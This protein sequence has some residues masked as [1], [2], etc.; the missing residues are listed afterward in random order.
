MAF[1]QDTVATDVAAL[2]VYYSKSQYLNSTILRVNQLLGLVPKEEEFS[3]TYMPVPI[4]SSGSP[5]ISVDFNDAYEGQDAGEYQGFK[6]PA[7]PIYNL[8]S[9]SNQAI[10]ASRNEVGGFKKL[11]KAQTDASMWQTSNFIGAYIFRDGTGSLASCKSGTSTG[12][13]T[14]TNQTDAQFFFKGLR[15]TASATAGATP[16]AGIG[17]VTRVNVPLGQIEVSTVRGGP[18]TTPSGW[19]DG[20]FLQLKGTFNKVPF[21]LQKWLPISADTYPGS[22]QSAA[23]N[24]LLGVDRSVD[25]SSYAGTFFDGSGMKIKD[26]LI[27]G[28]SQITNNG[29]SPS[30]LMTNPVSLA[31]LDKELQSQ[32]QYTKV[33]GPSGVSFDA[34]TLNTPFGP[35]PVLSDRNCP[36]KSC[37][38]LDMSQLELFSMG[39]CPGIMESGASDGMFHYQDADSVQ[40][41]VGTYWGFDIKKPRSSGAI[42]LGA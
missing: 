2:K 42:A 39:Q 18:A 36:P 27:N 5:G 28:V 24:E 12:V 13:I 35:I 37:W 15:L 32:F 38:A 4:M 34:I 16:R 8:A 21:G 20:D 25:S 33:E 11:M 31:T 10:K 1:G 19:V 23:V 41:R 3:G 22:G 26:A 40:C 7:L 30:I 17:Y 6:V 14:L 9:V 29:G